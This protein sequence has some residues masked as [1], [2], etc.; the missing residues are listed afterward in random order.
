M[1]GQRRVFVRRF[2]VDCGL[3]ISTMLTEQLFAESL[4][5]YVRRRWQEMKQGQLL[6]REDKTIISWCFAH[7]TNAAK[8]HMSSAEVKC[9]PD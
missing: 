1:L 2:N 8:T 3:N 9:V 5:Q 4:A 6:P 7:I